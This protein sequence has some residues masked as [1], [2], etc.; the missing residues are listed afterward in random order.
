[1]LSET[2]TLVQIDRLRED[3]AALRQ[4]IR[5]HSWEW[6]APPLTVVTSTSA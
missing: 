2:E 4:E 3:L 5:G 1:V 6:V